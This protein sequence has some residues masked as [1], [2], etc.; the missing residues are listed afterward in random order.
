M[1]LHSN[2]FS[3]PKQDNTADENDDFSD[4]DSSTGRFA[5]AD[6]ATQSS[7]AGIWAKMLVDKFIKTPFRASNECVAW[8]RHKRWLRWLDS[9][10]QNWRESCPK[11]VLP[12]YLEDKLRQGAFA[13]FV[14]LVLEDSQSWRAMA[15]GDSCLF[16]IREGNLTMRFPIQVSADFN[17]RPF[18]VGSTIEPSEDSITKMVKTAK[19]DWQTGDQL[20]LLTDALAQWFLETYEAE[21]KPWEQTASIREATNPQE[22]FRD[23][24]EELREKQLLRDDD[25]TMLIVRT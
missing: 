5:I 16:Q 11:G 7:Y 4:G 21:G 9:I 17:N 23:W 14:G 18:L 1:Q 6:G 12:W 13:T 10:Q 20:L 19:G 25:V 8:R 2:R 15:V 22:R 24:I 3:L